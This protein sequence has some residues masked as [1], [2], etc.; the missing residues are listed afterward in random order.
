MESSDKT[1]LAAL[2]DILLETRERDFM[3]PGLPDVRDAMKTI[4]E[5][6]NQ[7]MLSQRAFGYILKI[8]WLNPFHPNEISITDMSDLPTL[9]IYDISMEYDPSYWAKIGDQL[10]EFGQRLHDERKRLNVGHFTAKACQMNNTRRWLD[11][12]RER[13][14]H[15]NMYGV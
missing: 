14:F 6:A 4:D 8:R 1:P 10:I 5:F 9:I 3:L 7:D 12:Q 15:I 2:F 11:Y 13:I